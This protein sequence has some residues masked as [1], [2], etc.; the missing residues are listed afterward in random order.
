MSSPRYA[1]GG[2]RQH[3]NVWFRRMHFAGRIV[4]ALAAGAIFGFLAYDPA[5][6]EAAQERASISGHLKQPGDVTDDRPW[7]HVD[8]TREAA[9]PLGWAGWLRTDVRDD[10]RPARQDRQ[11]DASNLSASGAPRADRSLRADDVITA[12]PHS[13]GPPLP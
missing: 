1:G 5:A 12:E 8:A 13:R 9:D 4:L 2:R 3:G 10:N 11:R 6:R 7:L